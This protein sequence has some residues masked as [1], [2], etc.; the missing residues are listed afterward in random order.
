MDDGAVRLRRLEM[1]F[2]GQPLKTY[3]K[4]DGFFEPAQ[5]LHAVSRNPSRTSPARF[6]AFFLTARDEKELVLPERP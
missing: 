4:G 6:L 5:A 3:K 2:E 1:Q